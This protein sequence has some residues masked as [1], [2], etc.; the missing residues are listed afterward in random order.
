MSAGFCSLLSARGSRAVFGALV[1][2]SCAL[3][4]PFGEVLNGAREGARAPQT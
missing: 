3:R 1:G 4:I 2:N